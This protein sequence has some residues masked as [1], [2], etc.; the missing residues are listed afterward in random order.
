M[1][2]NIVNLVQAAFSLP[3]TDPKMYSP[4]TLA[5]I[6]DAIYELVI[7][8]MLVERGN[9]QVNWFVHLHKKNYFIKLRTS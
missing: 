5:Y 8:T 4:L 6:G 3:E 1:E 7:R 9:E 2:E